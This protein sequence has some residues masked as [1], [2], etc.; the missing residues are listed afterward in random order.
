MSAVTNAVT[1]PAAARSP[2]VQLQYEIVR[3]GWNRK[4]AGR[5]IF[6]LCIHIAA[7]LGGIAIFLATH[8]L[9]VRI[10]GLW[11]STLGLM[12]VATNSHTSSHYATS[13]KRWV[14]EFLSFLGYP[15]FMS[16]SATFWWHK[17]CKVHHPAPNVIGVDG[18]ADLLPWFAMT[19]QEIDGTRGLQ[20]FYHEKIQFWFFP[21]A[22]SVNGLN[23]SKNGIRYLIGELR[24][25]ERRKPKHYIDAAC[26]VAHY[27][28]WI[29]LP[30]F[31]FGPWHAIGFYL[32][33]MALMGYA[34][35][36][37]I[38][39]AHIPVDAGRLTRDFA[40]RDWL[41]LQA[42]ATVNFRAG[43]IGRL[44]SSGSDCQIEHH[45]FPYV[46]HVYYAQMSPVVKKVC[47]E[48]G[49]PYRCLPWAESVWR[50]WLVM[51]RPQQQLPDL[52]MFRSP[53][54]EEVSSPELAQVD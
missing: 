25:P 22:L 36:S 32:L 17:H 51:K 40:N 1:N 35:F 23:M 42:A 45:L 5:V 28:L 37:V 13:D 49:V 15:I 30:A 53:V 29:V 19:Q 7:T 44:V 26:M 8:Y 43:W 27:G 6:E 31:W 10:F 9:A 21:L 2:Y 20:R 46:S 33:R 48:H 47:E 50:C 16:L 54:A 39:P 4:P 41:L 11:I 52:E 14:N 3:R 24:S 18:D 12:G 34:M 38:A